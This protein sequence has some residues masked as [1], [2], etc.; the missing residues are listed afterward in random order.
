MRV[1]ATMTCSP[2]QSIRKRSW[3]PSRSRNSTL[4]RSV[5]SP[6]GDLSSTSTGRIPSLCAPP[7]SAADRRE[8]I[9]GIRIEEPAP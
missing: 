9:A 3:S 1:A 5:A 6:S 8:R 7:A 2:A 4:P